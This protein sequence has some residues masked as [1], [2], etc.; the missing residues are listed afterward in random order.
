M[1]LK[2]EIGFLLAN[3]C[4]KGLG[5]SRAAKTG[6]RHNLQLL[7]RENTALAGVK[8]S[9]L[10]TVNSCKQFCTATEPRF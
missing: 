2:T 7:F 3:F 9:T 10:R 5:T 8:R 6:C 4:N 1:A